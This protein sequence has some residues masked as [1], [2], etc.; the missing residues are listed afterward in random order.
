M[1]YNEAVESLK[2]FGKI[3]I[4]IFILSSVCLILNE[5]QKSTSFTLPES[6]WEEDDFDMSPV[7]KR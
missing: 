1:N 7:Q 4:F 2:N 6:D 5:C 3:F